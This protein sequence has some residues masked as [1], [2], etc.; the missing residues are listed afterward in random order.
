[1]GGRIDQ[2]LDTY[3]RLQRGFPES[4]EC[5]LS[6]LVAGRL[7]LDRDR[8]DLAAAQFR[9]YLATD[10]AGGASE[11]ALVG[12]ASASNRMG[13]FSEEARD[14]RLLLAEHP[15]SI[16][17]RRARVRLEALESQP[18]G[19]SGSAPAEPRLSP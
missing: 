7:W 11:E 3:Q 14:W 10:P 6:Y 15:G 8:A 5:R 12:H 1:V 16:Y 9:Q 19:T 2:A 17:A 18:V 4:R 13:H